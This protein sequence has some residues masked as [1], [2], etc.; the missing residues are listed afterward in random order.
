M[1]FDPF[2]E[3]ARPTGLIGQHQ[4]QRTN[5]TEEELAALKR[6][7]WEG[8]N[9]AA[10][11]KRIGRTANAC[12]AKANINGFKRRKLIKHITSQFRPWSVEQDDELRDLRSAGVAVFK[13]AAITGRSRKAVSM[14]IYHLGLGGPGGR[15]RACGA[16]S[17]QR[18]PPPLSPT[19]VMVSMPRAKRRP[20]EPSRMNAWGKDKDKAL[21]RA[22][23]G[24]LSIYAIAKRLGKTAPQVAQRG[25]ELELGERPRHARKCLRCKVA[26][27]PEDWTLDWY[28][29]K[30]RLQMACMTEDLTMPSNPSGRIR[31]K[32]VLA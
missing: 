4:K 22:W 25:R 27:V 12:K 6:H 13:I 18:P 29:K 14:R 31:S 26:F 23:Q 16:T 1:S 19:T 21:R 32:H 28:C 9:P 10:I 11:S 17:E 2:A 30:H 3:P 20:V 5:W 24:P 15:G 7:W 8:L